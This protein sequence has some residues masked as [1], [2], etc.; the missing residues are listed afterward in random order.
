MTPENTP[1]IQPFATGP[2]APFAVGEVPRSGW[3]CI[4]PVFDHLSP[5]PRSLGAAL[6]HS[7]PDDWDDAQVD[8]YARKHGFDREVATPET[9]ATIAANFDLATTEGRG[10]LVTINHSTYTPANDSR[11]AGWIKALHAD[12]GLLWAWIEWTPWGHSMIDNAEFIFF[13]TE[14]NWTDFTVTERGAEPQKLAALTCTNEN[15]HKGQIPCTNTQTNPNNNTM[16]KAPARA[17]NS[18]EIIQP[19]AAEPNTGAVNTD[20]ENKDAA[21]NTEGD[22]EDP[23]AATN[24][25]GNPDDPN[26]PACN[27]GDGIGNAIQSIASLL[28]LPETATPA[29]LLAAVESLA[30]SNEELREALAE[31][32][33]AAGT[34]GAATNS[35]RRPAYPYLVPGRAANTSLARH[36]TAPVK[37]VQKYMGAKPVE[38][39]SQDAAREEYIERYIADKEKKM[40]RS[41]NVGEYKRAHEEARTNWQRGQR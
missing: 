41:C 30:K 19:T 38:V 21:T 35:A 1:E 36:G 27:E 28:N 3:F 39:N 31:A 11:A 18:E 16:P 32:N 29:D 33:A 37:K 9:L 22:P 2:R 6:G 23:N 17:K 12:G 24:T 14:Y 4:E 15:R 7:I 34:G 5:S 26:A 13:S 40:G 20:D 25:E 10:L 8:A